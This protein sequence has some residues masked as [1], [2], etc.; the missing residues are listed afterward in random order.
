LNDL[1]SNCC[2]TTFST[3]AALI[4]DISMTDHQKFFRQILEKKPSKN[5]SLRTFLNH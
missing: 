4:S 1:S 2:G 3:G 5:I